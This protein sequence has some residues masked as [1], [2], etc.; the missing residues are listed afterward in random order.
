MRINQIIG[1]YKF[2][3]V[4]FALL[5]SIDYVRFINHSNIIIMIQRVIC[6]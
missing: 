2:D 1:D 5:K 6:L 4:C 3:G